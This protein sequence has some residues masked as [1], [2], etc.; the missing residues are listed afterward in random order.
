MRVGFIGLG[1]MGEPM[2]RNIAAKAAQAGVE[3]VTGYDLNAAPLDRLAEAGVHR[4]ASAGAVAAEADLVFLSL[5]GGQQVEALLLGDGNLLSDLR[6]GAVLVDL[7]TSPVA[8]ARR[9]AGEAEA[10]GLRFADAPVA[11]TRQAAE[12]GS[13]AVMV[14]AADGLFPVIEPVIRCF[15]TD[16]IHC[17]A[18]GNGQMVKILNNMVLFQNGLALAEALTVARRAGMDGE[19]LFEALSAGS[20]DSFA[21]HNHGAKALLPGNFPKQAFST[22]YAAKD[23]AY[24]LDLARQ[25]NRRLPGAETVRALFEEAHEAGYGDD[26]WPGIIRLIDRD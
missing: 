20:A 14:G 2:C 23:L 22:D 24:A 3:S 17:G 9:L 25:V 12:A 8:L 11:R 10:R 19:T 15:A 7:S 6:A 5:P 18:P 16:V 1:V 21:L 26:Y 4:A 13:L